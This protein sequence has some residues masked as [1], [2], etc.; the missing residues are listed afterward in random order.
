[1]RANALAGQ[2]LLVSLPL[3]GLLA[4]VLGIWGSEGQ[5]A[6]AMREHKNAHPALQQAVRLFTDWG[7]QLMYLP[8]LALL[9][10]GWRRRD[11][12]PL[13]FVVAYV[14]AQVVI[15]LVLLHL[16]KMALGRPRPDAF[17]LL[18]QPLTLNPAFHS[19]P[20]GHTAEIT[21]S[22]LAL[23]LWLGRARWALALGL[24]VALMGLSRVY[25]L[26]HYP[27]DVLFGWMFG[28]LSGFA[29]Y[30]F[31]TSKEGSPGHG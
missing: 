17:T 12:R 4:L 18:H 26:Q 31:G 10:R 20:S 19:L 28:A 9:A 7:N 27:S 29:A 23:A 8:F 3:L 13:R 6:A 16:T 1:M 22:C 2:F 21:G 14:L 30:T 5:I 25:L 11:R 15:C 24:F